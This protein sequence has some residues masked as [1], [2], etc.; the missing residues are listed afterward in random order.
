[1]LDLSQIKNQIKISSEPD[2]NQIRTKS[3]SDQNQIRIRLDW[4]GSGTGQSTVLYSVVH[5]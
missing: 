2:Q 3:E 5:W 4:I 1:M